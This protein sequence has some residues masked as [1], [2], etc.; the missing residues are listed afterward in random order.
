M[1]PKEEKGIHPG[2]PIPSSTL[3]PAPFRLPVPSLEISPVE[4]FLH[5]AH[6]PLLGWE[7]Q[8]GQETAR[9]GNP[10][11]AGRSSGRRGRDPGPAHTEPYQPSREQRGVS[12]NIYSES[13][14]TRYSI[15]ADNGRMWGQALQGR[16]PTQSALRPHQGH[17]SWGR[18]VCTTKE[19]SQ[20]P[21]LGP[22]QAVETHCPVQTA[23]STPS[24]GMGMYPSPS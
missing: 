21:H 8:L 7:E 18:P 10:A 12:K 1:R 20:A 19:G 14:L 9:T 5:G 3:S 4:A 23:Q 17:R 15:S 16:R 22:E 24:P 11:E 2:V 13:K 6:W